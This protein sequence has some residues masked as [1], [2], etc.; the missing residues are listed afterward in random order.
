MFEANVNVVLTE[1]KASVIAL[2]CDQRIVNA[3]IVVI[4]LHINIVAVDNPIILVKHDLTLHR[5]LLTIGMDIF[6]S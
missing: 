3:L 2:E 5:N 1:I 4:F 6:I